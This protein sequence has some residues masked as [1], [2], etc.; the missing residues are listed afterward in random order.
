MNNLSVLESQLLTDGS[1]LGHQDLPSV[2]MASP[3][4][5]SNQDPTTD[6]ID[7]SIDLDD[8]YPEINGYHDSF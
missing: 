7:G 4:T 2:A 3:S 8:L 5:V 6:T 1:L